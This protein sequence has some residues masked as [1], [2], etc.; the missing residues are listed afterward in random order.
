MTNS[1]G[2]SDIK[3]KV[4]TNIILGIQIQGENFRLFIEDKDGALAYKVKEILLDT[5][6]WFIFS[7]FGESEVYPKGLKGFNKYGNTFYYKSV[8]L[9]AG[10]SVEE[11]VDIVVEYL[12]QIRS[13]LSIIKDLICKLT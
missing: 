8:K 13:N 3:F 1:Q 4:A 7:R 11:I 10:F 6:L 12:N 2:L 5:N 9:G